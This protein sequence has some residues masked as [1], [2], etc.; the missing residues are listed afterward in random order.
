MMPNR[1]EDGRGERRRRFA[2]GEGYVPEYLASK[3]GISTQQARDLIAEVG[4]D[5]ERLNLAASTVRR[6]RDS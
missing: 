4:S 1:S 3:H 2:A 5:R 6:A